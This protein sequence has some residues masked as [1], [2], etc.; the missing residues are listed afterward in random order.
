[1]SGQLIE[2]EVNRKSDWSTGITIGFAEMVGNRS[3][4]ILIFFVMLASV[5]VFGITK[6]TAE[7]QF[8]KA[9]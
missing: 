8:I 2:I 5:S 1:M 7:N 4:Q 3:N 6:L 9:F